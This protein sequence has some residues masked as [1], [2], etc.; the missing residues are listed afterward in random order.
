MPQVLRPMI[1]VA[2][3]THSF[4]TVHTERSVHAT[5]FLGNPTPVDAEWSLAH[6]PAPP[7][8]HR[9]P[10]SKTSGTLTTLERSAWQGASDGVI[11]KYSGEQFSKPETGRQ[12][13]RTSRGGP[14]AVQTTA[15]AVEARHDDEVA[16]D[17]ALPVVV[18]KTAAAAAAVLV[19]DP[20]VFDFGERGG[21]APGVKLPLESSA[22]CLP[23]DWNRLDV[24][25]TLCTRDKEIHTHTHTQYH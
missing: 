13:R 6:V 24:R 16:P 3:A 5:L 15:G 14:L 4:G 17:E 19:D 20:S 11:T 12:I 2:P 21:V 1:T 10:S 23:Q 25:A 9:V 7:P 18:P 22:A 8:K